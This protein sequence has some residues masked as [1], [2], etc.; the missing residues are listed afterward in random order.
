MLSEDL[1]PTQSTPHLEVVSAGDVER[2]TISNLI[3]L[4]L[5]DMASTTPFPVGEDGKYAYTMLDEFWEHPYVLK[6]D[7]EIAGFALVIDRCPITQT[8]SCWFL[9]EFFVLRPYRRKSIGRAAF[10]ELKA[11]HPGLWHVATVIDNHKGEAFWS[12]IIPDATCEKL[13][14]QFDGMNWIVRSFKASA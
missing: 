14:A 3:Q 4:Y 1:L 6:A 5:Y 9:A 2:P 10:T 8:S 11:R 12:T 13:D 7:G